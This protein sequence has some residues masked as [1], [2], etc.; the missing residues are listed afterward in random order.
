MDPLVK[1][2]A[3]GVYPDEAAWFDKAGLIGHRIGRYVLSLSLDKAGG[4]IRELVMGQ[5]GV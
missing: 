2:L 3:D 5:E 1:W 4:L